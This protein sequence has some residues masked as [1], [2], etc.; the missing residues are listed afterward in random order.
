MVLSRLSEAGGRGAGG[1][2][3]GV[4][5]NPGI[6]AIAGIG[7]LLL[8]FAGDIRK[9][10]GS[11]GESL[12]KFGSVELPDITLPSINFPQITFPSF[13]FPTIE[14]PKFEFPDVN[15]QIPD[16]IGGASMAIGGAG[17]TVTDFFEGFRSDL[18]QSFA[19]LFES[20]KLPPI[21]EGDFTEV[22][23]AGARSARG[24]TGTEEEFTQIMEEV[25]AQ[26]KIISKLP[27]SDQEFGFG[28]PSFEGGF[29]FENP[30]D[31]L[32]EVLAQFPQLTASQ[33]ADFLGQF[34]GILP[35]QLPGIDPDIKNLVANIEGENIQVEF[36]TPGTLEKEATI[37]ACT[38]CKLFNLNCDQCAEAAGFA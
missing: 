2:L 32:S 8:F 25:V 19:N 7:L 29:V 38:T 1:F 35:S 10:F 18:E 17:E 13:E 15:F 3:G 28:G 33:A 11:L 24:A 12:G 6:I 20:Q 37:A 34:S 5:N 4:A 14:F 30:I 16:V 36:A 21:G 27:D 26:P 9:A 22:G 23:Q 31:T